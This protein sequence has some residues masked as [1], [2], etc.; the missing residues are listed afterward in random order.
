MG[1]GDVDVVVVVDVVV[2]ADAEAG[3]GDGAVGIIVPHAV[4]NPII[5]RTSDVSAVFIR[6]K[7]V[8]GS[9][10]GHFALSTA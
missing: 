9:S 8:V 4:L 3:A 2:D 6:D 1:K 7:S 5:D 10:I